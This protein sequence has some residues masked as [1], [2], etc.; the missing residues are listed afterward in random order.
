M[1]S[2]QTTLTREKTIDLTLSRE[3]Q[4]IVV[5]DLEIHPERETLL[6]IGATGPGGEPR[7][8][9]QGNLKTAEALSRLEQSFGRASFV[10]GHN[11]IGHDLPWLRKHFPEFPLLK[12]PALDTL[13]LSPL[14]FPKN[15]YHHLVKDYK[16]V[17]TARNDP[18]QDC[19]QVELVFQDEIRAFQALPREQLIFYGTLMHR[20]Y[21]QS[22]LGHL[23]AVLPWGS[24]YLVCSGGV[25]VNALS[26]RGSRIYE[27]FMSRGFNAKQVIFLAALHRKASQEDQAGLNLRELRC[28]SWYVPLFQVVWS[29]GRN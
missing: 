2:S 21:P 20:S 25:P 1:I 28:S 7:L 14:A 27:N 6:K 18:V 29:R 17:R 24:R 19:A 12:L 9:F 13:H 10:L 16:L 8:V 15:P 26:D 4:N 5:L 3:F 22:G 23:F 11:I